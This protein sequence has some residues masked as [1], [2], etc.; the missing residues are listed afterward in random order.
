MKKLQT[1]C[2]I[3][4]ISSLFSQGYAV[5]NPVH[6]STDSTSILAKKMKKQVG[7][8]REKIEKKIGRKLK[9]KERIVLAIAKKKHNKEQKKVLEGF[10]LTGFILSMLGV[11]IYSPIS[12]LFFILSIIFCGIGLN[13]IKKNRAKFRGKSFGIAGLVISITVFLIL[14]FFFL[15]YSFPP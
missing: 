9:L 13:R 2:I 4:L 8:D 1:L 7:F 14:L 10:S 6:L 15:T 5:G 11:T 12:L 3:L